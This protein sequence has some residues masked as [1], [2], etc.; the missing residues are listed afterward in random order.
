MIFDESTSSLDTE[1]ESAIIKNIKNSN[2]GKT[3]I[4]VS[5]RIENLKYCE[6]IYEVNEGTIFLKHEKEFI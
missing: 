1:T 5:H 6:K 3:I 4:I 2:L